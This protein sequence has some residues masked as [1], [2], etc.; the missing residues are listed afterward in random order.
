MCFVFRSFHHEKHL[1]FQWFKT[2][3]ATWFQQ[4]VWKK[5]A[6]I[7]RGRVSTYSEIAKAIGKPKAARAVGNALNRNPFH[8]NS[9]PCH[10]VVKS[11]GKI[12]GYA[13]G[14]SEKEKKLKKEGVKIEK[15][16][17]VNFE[18]VL[19]CF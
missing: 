1:T 10:R 11:D 13:H 3:M 5:C 14:A 7:P 2:Y 18:K 15:R 6:E 12:G 16:K 17:I 9:V 4:N 19:Y 8:S